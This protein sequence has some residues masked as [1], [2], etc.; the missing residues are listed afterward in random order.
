MTIRFGSKGAWGLGLFPSTGTAPLHAKSISLMRKEGGCTDF[1]N[2]LQIRKGG[3][4]YGIAEK[5]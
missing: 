1:G 2:P 3:G 4:T 5:L